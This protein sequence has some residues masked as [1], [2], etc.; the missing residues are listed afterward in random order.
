[1][2]ELVQEFITPKQQQRLREIS[3]LMADTL[4]T[5]VLEDCG[6]SGLRKKCLALIANLR[7]E[8]DVL[9]RSKTGLNTE[10]PGLKRATKVGGKV[11]E[12]GLTKEQSL[13]R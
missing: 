11:N 9:N 12:A 4:R 1:M 6:S 7:L 3:T 2:T 10:A 5:G 13:L 8:C